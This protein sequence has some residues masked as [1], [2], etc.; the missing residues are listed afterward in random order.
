[1]AESIQAPMAESIQAPTDKSVSFAY[2][3]QKEA[4]YRAEQAKYKTEEAYHRA[5]EA[6]HNAE[7]AKHNAGRVMFEAQRN[8]HENRLRFTLANQEYHDN[9]SLSYI[10]VMIAENKLR[11]LK[12]LQ[13]LKLLQE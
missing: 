13:Q 12:A 1:M 8:T 5:M 2:L 3:A 9:E 6:K 7:E 11:E 10:K 4:E